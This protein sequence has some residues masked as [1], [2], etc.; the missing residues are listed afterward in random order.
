MPVVVSG[1]IAVGEGVM[2]AVE[3][4]V[5][6][7]TPV[8]VIVTL[9][10][11]LVDLGVAVGITRLVAVGMGVRVAGFVAIV[12][13]FVATFVGAVVAVIG[14]TPVNGLTSAVPAA[15]VDVVDVGA[16]DVGPVVPGRAARDV[17]DRPLSPLLLPVSVNCRT[18]E[19]SAFITKIS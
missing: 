7:P 15:S 19:P 12:T 18:A 4:A 17:H 8:G 3:E 14:A 6:D 16:I 5:G 1:T 10:A 11:G 9:P 13:A 2:L